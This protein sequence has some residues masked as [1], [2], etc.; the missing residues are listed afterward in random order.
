MK[1]ITRMTQNGSVDLETTGIRSAV[2][3]KD[4][5]CVPGEFGASD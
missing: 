4:A 5:R 3:F 2:R 1:I